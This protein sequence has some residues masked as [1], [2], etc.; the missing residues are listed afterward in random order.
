MLFAD[1]IV[2]VDDSCEGV[3]TKLESWKAALES[4]GFRLSRKKAEYVEFVLGE[5]H[6]GVALGEDDIPRKECFKYLGSVFQSDGGIDRDI[7][8]RIQAGWQK[9]RCASGVLCDKKVPLKLKGKFYKTVV[10]P[11]LLYGA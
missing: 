4:K 7:E 2:L 6:V 10:R 9:W 11:A 5:S 1:D 8:H 3:S